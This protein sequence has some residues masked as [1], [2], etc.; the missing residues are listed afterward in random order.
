MQIELTANCSD[1]E[2]M[3]QIKHGLSE[4]TRLTGVEFDETGDLVAF[5]FE[6]DAG[7]A[8]NICRQ[9]DNYAFSEGLIEEAI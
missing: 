7:D 6:V 2:Q 1:I 8:K 9:W 4:E 5:S 3:L